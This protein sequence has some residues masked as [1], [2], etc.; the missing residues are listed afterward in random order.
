MMGVNEV[1]FLALILTWAAIL[2]ILVSPISLLYLAAWARARAAAIVKSRET[3]RTVRA[4]EYRRLRID[5][6]PVLRTET[7]EPWFKWPKFFRRVDKSKVL[8]P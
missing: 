7:F 5:H 4:Q 2:L 3:F 8:E 6:E 1:L